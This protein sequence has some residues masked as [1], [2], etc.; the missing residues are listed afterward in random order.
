VPIAIISLIDL[1]RQYHVSDYGV[2]GIQKSITEIDRKASLCTQTILAKS[3]YIVVPDLT[4]DPRFCDNVTVAGP[5]FVRFYAAAPLMAPEGY[6]LGTLCLVDVVVRPQGLT[7]DQTATLIDLTNMIVKVMVDRRTQLLNDKERSET[8]DKQEDPGEMLADVARDIVAPLTG[9]QCSL[10]MLCDNHGVRSM[11]SPS[12]LDLL[13]TVTSS[14]DLVVRICRDALGDWHSSDTANEPDTTSSMPLVTPPARIRLDHV[15]KSLRMIVE[16]I[17]KKVACIVALDQSVPS[18]IL[19]NDGKLF[20]CALNLLTFALRRTENGIVRLTIRADDPSSLLVFECEDT[21]ADIAVEEYP[22]LFR[23][24]RDGLSSVALV[25]ESMDGEYGFR[26]RGIDPHGNV[27]ADVNGCRQA[28]SIFWFSVPL[29]RAEQPGLES[30]CPVDAVPPERSSGTSPSLYE[31][32]LS[33]LV[34]TG[35]GFQSGQLCRPAGGCGAAVANLAATRITPSVAELSD[36]DSRLDA[37]ME[38][39]G[40]LEPIPISGIRRSSDTTPQR[41]RRW[42]IIDDSTDVRRSLVLSLNGFGYDAI[43]ATNGMEGLKEMQ[44]SLF[45]GVFCDF[46]MPILVGTE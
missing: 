44:Q 29:V 41:R 3:D 43:Q 23:R 39:L 40:D 7:E 15:V 9:I 19:A 30:G 2:N 28:G 4:K 10:S 14:S 12:Q 18:E 38:Q 22:S 6:K 37:L 17:P 42:L 24:R 46:A 16:A 35:L 1:G 8:K 32:E 26:P 45:D 25:V 5:P 21:G 20:R 13:C 34:E 11:L 27:L 36:D 31:R 33:A